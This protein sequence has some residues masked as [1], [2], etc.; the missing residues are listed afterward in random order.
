MQEFA[1]P[2]EIMKP[3][4]I[5]SLSARVI[6]EIH[7]TALLMRLTNG[8]LVARVWD[9]WKARHHA[10]QA[11]GAGAPSLGDLLALLQAVSALPAHIK[12]PVEVH[13]LLG[14]YARSLAAAGLAVAALS[15]PP[16]E[17]TESFR[18]SIPPTCKD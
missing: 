18:D 9:E 15:P 13:Q 3:W 8:Q 6:V 2:V 17:S 5:K 10:P 16:E 7:D 1:K 11:F 14:H 4:T 12:I